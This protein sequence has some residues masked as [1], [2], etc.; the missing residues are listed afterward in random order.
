MS[1]FLQGQGRKGVQGSKNK[2]HSQLSFGLLKGKATT[3]A[4]RS[5]ADHHCRIWEWHTMHLIEM[6]SYFDGNIPLP[7]CVCVC[8]CMCA[9]GLHCRLRNVGIKY[10]V[11]TDSCTAV[12]FLTCHT[13]T[14]ACWRLWRR[15]EKSALK[16]KKKKNWQEKLHTLDWQRWQVTHWNISSVGFVLTGLRG[17]NQPL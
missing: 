15:S 16:K 9:R 7:V 17:Q 14:Q 13:R 1:E 8:V 5:S 10:A 3:T 12:A 6:L 2:Q 11:L 4:G